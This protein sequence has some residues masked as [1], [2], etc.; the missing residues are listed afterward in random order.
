MLDL[1][2]MNNV[3]SSS[4]ILVVGAGP[5]GLTLAHSLAAHGADVTVVDHKPGPSRE[6]KALALN[7]ASQYGLELL[8]L[9]NAVGHSG[10]HLRRVNLMW[11]GK[12]FSAVD[13]KHLDFH[14]KSVITQPQAQTERELIEAL[15]LRNV[16]IHWNTQVTRVDASADGVEV[17]L[18]SAAGDIAHHRFAYVAGCDGKN[19]VVR[20]AMDAKFTGHEYPMYFVV[21]DYM[22]TWDAPRDQGYY[23][24][25][26]DTFFIVL[27][28][29]DEYWRVVVKHDG[30]VP[31]DGPPRSEEIV[32][33]VS[34]FMSPE[35]FA[36]EPT[37]ISRAP[38]YLR[39]SDRLRR[40]RL[41]LAGDA[42]HLYSPIGG[43]GMNTGMQDALNLGWKLAYCATGRGRDGLLDSYEAERLEIIRTTAAMTDRSTRMITRLDRD[44]AMLAPML[45]KLG[46]RASFRTVLPVVHAGLGVASRQA[47]SGRGQPAAGSRSAG[48]LCL[49]LGSLLAQLHPTTAQPARPPVVL[50]IMRV[51]STSPSEAAAACAAELSALTRSFPDLLRGVLVGAADARIAELRATF[52]S[53][54]AL[55]LD[56]EALRRLGAGPDSLLLVYPDGVIGYSGTWSDAS[57]LARVVSDQLIPSAERPQASRT[58]ASH[59]AASFVASNHDSA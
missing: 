59:V 12:R 53:L 4:R 32:S 58:A 11:E 7:V 28:V 9:A 36:G 41:V 8:G 50:A 55:A 35:L 15:R 13:L 33:C 17:E 5:T 1:F 49:G 3:Q 42:A 46:N 52:P 56:A 2:S 23:Y 51:D 34:R 44:T 47:L 26:E 38:F 30:E 24:I 57:A 21:G 43:T 16:S 54:T 22:L 31:L 29:G 40:G 20:S 6:S 14:L 48:D 37:W 27:P 18:R 10:C 25:Y 19:S 39:L 45:P